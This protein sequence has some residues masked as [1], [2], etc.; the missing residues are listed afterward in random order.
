M[1]IISSIILGTI[2]LGG[3]IYMK[4]VDFISELTFVAFVLMSILTGIFVRYAD[5][6]KEF[7]LKGGKIILKEIQVKE[8]NI[9]QMERNVKALALATIDLVESATEDLLSVGDG[10]PVG[11]ENAKNR[12]KQLSET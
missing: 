10:N 12:I 9:E 5:E 6:I 11:Y 2:F 1:K 8:R 7:D 4:H 3:A